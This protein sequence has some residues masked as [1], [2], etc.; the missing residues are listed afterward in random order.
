MDLQMPIMDGLPAAWEIRK[1][2]SPPDLPIPA[3]T[4]NTMT[5]DREDYPA[6]GM[7]DPIAKPIKPASPYENTGS[8]R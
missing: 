2:P 6:A 7:N 5:A 1:G 8:H 3:M 4:A